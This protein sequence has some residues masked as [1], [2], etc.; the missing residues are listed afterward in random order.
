MTMTDEEQYIATLVHPDEYAKNVSQIASI[1][2]H[3]LI[4]VKR[5]ELSLKPFELLQFPTSQCTSITYEIKWAIVPMI[6]GALLVALVLFILSSDV[7][8]GTRVPV[9]ALAVVLIFGGLLARGPKR[10]RFTF[11]VNGKPMRWQSK[12]G[13]FKYKIASVKRIIAYAKDSGLY[14]EIPR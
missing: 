12:A 13:D 7:M 2:T 1:S 9:G 4:Y 10:H 6:F 11:L 14:R 3:R 5:K 8:V